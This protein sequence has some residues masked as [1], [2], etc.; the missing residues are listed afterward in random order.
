MATQSPHGAQSAGS[1]RRPI[2]SQACV[3]LSCLHAAGIAQSALLNTS[4][5]CRRPC[6]IAASSGTR[7]WWQP[8]CRRRRRPL[9]STAVCNRL[10]VAWCGVK[11]AEVPGT[12]I[13]TCH[14]HAWHLGPRHFGHV[15]GLHCFCQA[16]K[17]SLCDAGRCIANWT[18]LC[19]LSVSIRWTPACL[20]LPVVRCLSAPAAHTALLRVQILLAV[21]MCPCL[22]RSSA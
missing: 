20:P 8:S 13:A 11:W 2:A 22:Q 15:Q 16:G 4:C 19:S 12:S 7:S 10:Q 3:Q 5:A 18:R 17:G 6:S 21:H 9:R 14:F 1:W